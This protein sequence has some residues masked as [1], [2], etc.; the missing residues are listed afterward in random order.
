MDEP[1]PQPT[2]ELVEATMSS[3]ILSGGPVEPAVV[4]ASPV[5]PDVVAATFPETPILPRMPGALRVELQHELDLQLA[6]VLAIAAAASFVAADARVAIVIGSLGFAAV[7]IRRIDRSVPFSF[8]EG[9]VGYR[10]D[11]GWPHGIQE[12]DDVRWNWANSKAGTGSPQMPGGPP[13]RC[14]SER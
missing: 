14:A 8:G 4:T 3:P 11:V 7:G 10:A 2:V 6:I 5:E 12:D 13:N 9:F 1:E